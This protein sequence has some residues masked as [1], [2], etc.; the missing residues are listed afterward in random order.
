MKWLYKYLSKKKKISGLNG[1][2]IRNLKGECHE[3]KT[4]WA[5]F[6]LQFMWWFTNQMLLRRQLSKVGHGTEKEKVSVYFREVQG[7]NLK[8]VS[9]TFF[10]M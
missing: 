7:Q 10:K 1:T 8:N 6:I 5:N 9:L 3:D 2:S 4:I